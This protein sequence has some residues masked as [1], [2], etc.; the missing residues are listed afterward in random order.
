M[1][2]WLRLLAAVG[3]LA[4]ALVAWTLVVLLLAGKL[5]F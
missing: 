5:S 4:V 1:S 2:V 3:A